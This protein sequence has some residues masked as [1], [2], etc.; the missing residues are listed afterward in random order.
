MCALNVV[1]LHVLFFVSCLILRVYVFNFVFNS[2]VFN[3]A[4]AVF[5]FVCV[6]LIL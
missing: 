6:R 4:R 5:V 2:A 1:I 3:F